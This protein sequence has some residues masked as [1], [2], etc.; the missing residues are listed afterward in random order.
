MQAISAS[1][2]RIASSSVGRAPHAVSI[3]A[4]AKALLG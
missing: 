2:R 1:I 4:H 3:A